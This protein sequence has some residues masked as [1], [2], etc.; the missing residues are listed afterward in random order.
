MGAEEG[1]L[2][3]G[4]AAVVLHVQQEYDL[5][6]TTPSPPFTSNPNTARDVEL[7]RGGDVKVLHI[8]FVSPDNKNKLV[9]ALDESTTLGN[10][11]QP[12]MLYRYVDL[13]RIRTTERVLKHIALR[14]CPAQHRALVADCATFTYNFLTELLGYLENRGSITEDELENHRK[15]LVRVIHIED[16]IQGES[17]AASRQDPYLAITGQMAVRSAGV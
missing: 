5:H 6:D 3:L 12:L 16:G 7:R 11:E 15:A 13:Y 8:R 1:S 10:P 9:L 17:E 2:R 4:H 14:F